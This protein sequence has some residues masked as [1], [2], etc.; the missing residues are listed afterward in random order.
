M[1]DGPEVLFNYAFCYLY[2]SQISRIWGQNLL[3]KNEKELSVGIV[4][5]EEISLSFAYKLQITWKK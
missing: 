4:L 1:C 5:E 2:V 3:V